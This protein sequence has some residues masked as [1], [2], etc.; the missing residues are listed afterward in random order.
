MS[1]RKEAK[2]KSS[3]RKGE[4]RS[5]GGYF[6]SPALLLMLILAAGGGVVCVQLMNDCQDLERLIQKREKKRVSLR[7]SY[8]H[9]NSSWNKMRSRDNVL[10]KLSEWNIVMGEPCYD[11][12]VRLPAGG[13][14]PRRHS[15]EVTSVSY[16]DHR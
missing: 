16:L 6:G 7:D 14:L 12:I 1:K 4:M 15:G 2:R 5:K 10:A 11:Q 9:Y 3:G 8:V 13:S